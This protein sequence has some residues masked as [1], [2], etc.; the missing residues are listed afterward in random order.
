MHILVD[1]A[2]KGE[3]T[4][5]W[6]NGSAPRTFR[7]HPENLVP[8]RTSLRGTFNGYG[9]TYNGRA[10]DIKRGHYHV[11]PDGSVHFT[12]DMKFD[13]GEPM[14]TC[15]GHVNSAETRLTGN[16]KLKHPDDYDGPQTSGAYA[17]YT[18]SITLH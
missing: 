11:R 3:I 18:A 14:E 2:W 6:D 4:T 8:D 16:I 12:F 1:R 9:S 13:S 7:L 5:S 15:S 17:D 10:F